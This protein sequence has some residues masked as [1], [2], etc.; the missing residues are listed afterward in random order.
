[1]KY[2]ATLRNFL[3]TRPL[4][5]DSTDKSSKSE[6]QSPGMGHDH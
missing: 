6:T 2:N 1:M 3:G 4:F 5:G